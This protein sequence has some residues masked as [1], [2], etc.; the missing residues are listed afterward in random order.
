MFDVI[1]KL[2]I[3]GVYVKLK[4]SMRSLTLQ[5]M[6]EAFINPWLAGATECFEY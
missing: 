4:L 5:T 3:S 6:Y 2:Y 1:S